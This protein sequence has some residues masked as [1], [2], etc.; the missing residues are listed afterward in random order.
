MSYTKSAR[1]ILSELSAQV[2]RD[3]S[4]IVVDYLGTET[5]VLR[6]AL[7]EQDILGDRDETLVTNLIANVIIKHPMGNNQWLFS[8][9]QN[10]NT[11]QTDAINLWEI[12]PI[13]MKIK[14]KADFDTEPV[15]IQKGDMIVELLKDEND[16]NI[17]I[18]M[19]VTKLLG[20]FENKYLYQ[21]MYEL[22]LYR[23][24][25]PSDIQHEIDKFIEDQTTTTRIT[26]GNTT[27]VTKTEHI[28]DATHILYDYA[29]AQYI[30]AYKIVA[31]NSSSKVELATNTNMNHV[32]SVIGISTITVNKDI[33]VS[34]QT[35]GKIRNPAWNLDIS[36]PIY[37]GI[38]GDLTQIAPTSGFVLK[39]GYA[40][41][42]D[43]I[44]ID[45]KE[46]FILI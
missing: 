2:K 43:S 6:I 22:A 27:V 20:G 38:N 10:D 23:G 9:L 45:L 17:P 41:S 36:L 19:Q 34:I 35:Y 29:A 18:I 21:K 40:L 25:I 39:I 44:F 46:P 5:Q 31:L 1:D 3:L 15:A 14:Y 26:Q 7:G 37:V 16:N 8:T 28:S 30:T 11:L 32:N 12:L 13:Q 4:D 42:S 33:L 24:T